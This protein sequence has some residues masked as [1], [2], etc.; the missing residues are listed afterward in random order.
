VTTLAGLGLRHCDRCSPILGVRTWVPDAHVQVERPVRRC[1]SVREI[2]SEQAGSSRDEVQVQ[3]AT[4]EDIVGCSLC[5]SSSVI[6]IL[7]LAPGPILAVE[8]EVRRSKLWLAEGESILPMGHY[9]ASR[10]VLPMRPS[11]SSEARSRAC[12]LHPSDPQVP[13]R[14]CFE[15]TTVEQR[16]DFEQKMVWP[17]HHLQRLF[18]KQFR[19]MQHRRCR[20]PFSATKLERLARS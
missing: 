8:Q 7:I 2:E 12:T 16:L 4:T 5:E 18:R 15:R 1:M 11:R 3:D 19:P 20:K 10:G 17:P 13:D 14:M 6:L 9:L